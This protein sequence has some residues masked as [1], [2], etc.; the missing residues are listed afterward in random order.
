MVG[1]LRRRRW[2][3]CHQKQGCQIYIFIRGF[4]CELRF[5][6]NIG[7]LIPFYFVLLYQVVD[8]NKPY[9]FCP[10]GIKKIWHPYPARSGRGKSWMS[11]SCARCYTDNCWLVST[12]TT[13]S[14][15]NSGT[16]HLPQ[17]DFQRVWYVDN[18]W[19]RVVVAG[20]GAKT[21][22]QSFLLSWVIKFS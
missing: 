20:D 7:E 12:W 9:D 19:Q 5:C 22:S 2:Q 6:I 15:R 17:G 14:Q 21:I 18:E 3:C 16:G 10:L 8:T 11:P 4:L 1:R 13:K